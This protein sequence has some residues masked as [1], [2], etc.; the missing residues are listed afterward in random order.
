MN[1]FM[2]TILLIMV[3][4]FLSACGTNNNEKII[5]ESDI[6][7]VY[8]DKNQLVNHADAIIEGQVISQ[9][10]QKDFRGFPVTDTLIRVTKILKGNP[11]KEVE[12]R[13]EGGE[14]DDMIYEPEENLLPT[15]EIGEIVT[16]FLTS[17]KGNRPDKDDFG[18]YV[19]GQ[20]QGK[21]VESNGM[22]KNQDHEFITNNFEAELL[23]IEQSN[24]INNLEKFY[25]EEGEESD[26]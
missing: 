26:I 9:E 16:V 17:N 14:T 1:K 21:F 12:I 24:R 3:F 4:S 15:F 13:V 7:V 19:V 2:A 22:L 10:V 25:L 23:T 8:F 6:E 20:A 11:D 18:Y 5:V